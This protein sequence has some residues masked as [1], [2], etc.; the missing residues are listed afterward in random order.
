VSLSAAARIG[1]QRFH[2]LLEGAAAM[3]HHFRTVAAA[4]NL[5]VL[6]GL[7][8]VW[9]RNVCGYGAWGVMPYDLRLRLLPAYLQQL[10]M[11]SNGKSVD[12]AGRPARFATAPVVFGEIGTDA[13]HSVFQALHQGS[14]IVP[15]NFVAVLRPDHDDREAQDELLANLLAQLTA[16]AEGRSPEETRAEL[17]DGA[18]SLLAHRSFAGNRPS[19]LIALDRLSARNLGMLLALYEHKTFVESVLWGVNAFD[20][21]GVELGKTLAPGIQAA[22]QGGASDNAGLA[23]LLAWIRE[24]RGGA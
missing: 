16:L 23:P 24:V 8:G 20:Q 2:R 7:I 6:L 3:D 21:W 19:E 17:G 1:P 13:Q 14:D 15:L 11:E 18:E 4:D 5:P 9:H 10:I 22:L 12:L